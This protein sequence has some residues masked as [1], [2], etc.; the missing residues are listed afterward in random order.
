M[1][2]LPF[3]VGL[4][5]KAH[6]HAAPIKRRHLY[7]QYVLLLRSAVNDTRALLG[8]DDD[9]VQVDELAAQ[10]EQLSRPVQRSARNEYCIHLLESAGEACEHRRAFADASREIIRDH[11]ELFDSLPAQDQR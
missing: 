2:D 1:N 5:E 7:G 3:S 11:N 6:G 9:E 4:V 8:E 10:I